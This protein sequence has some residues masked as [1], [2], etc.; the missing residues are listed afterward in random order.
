[1]DGAVDAG[2]RAAS[3]VLVSLRGDDQLK[4]DE[5]DPYTFEEQSKLFN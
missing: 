3:E 2:R 1:M 5:I 4:D